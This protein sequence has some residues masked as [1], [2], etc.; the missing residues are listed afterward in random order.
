[1]IQSHTVTPPFAAMEGT[2]LRLNTATTNSSN[3][4]RRPRTRFRCGCLASVFDIVK[5]NSRDRAVYP[6]GS[7]AFNHPMTRWGDGPIPPNAL[8]P[9]RAAPV[10]Q[11]PETEQLRQ[12]PPGDRKSVV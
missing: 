11:P 1:M 2:T 4:S 9:R 5:E 3:R 7:P 8:Q 10:L 12:I 6:S